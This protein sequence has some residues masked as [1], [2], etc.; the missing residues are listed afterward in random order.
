MNLVKKHHA[1]VTKKTK[2]RFE[3]LKKKGDK[4]SIILD[5]YTSMKN[6][7]YRYLN[8]NVHHT[9]DQWNLGLV[10]IHGSFPA[11]KI[12]DAVSKKLEQYG[13]S[14][15]SDVV[16]STSDGAAVR[17][18]FWR[19]S[20]CEQQL[21]ILHGIHLAIVDVLYREVT[22][23]NIDD[24]ADE[25]SDGSDESEE[26]DSEREMILRR[27]I[28]ALQWTCLLLRPPSYWIC[29]FWIMVKACQAI[30]QAYFSISTS[31]LSALTSWVGGNHSFPVAVWLGTLCWF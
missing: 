4:F 28:R 17:T 24:S 30:L 11:Q 2:L 6:R 18:K 1:E 22:E 15:E 12:N 20:S 14:H 7:R 29:C 25:E 8:I 19:I 27:N 9:S 21:Y 26:E 16:A 13:I 5:E 31:F 3:E 10:Q 23:G